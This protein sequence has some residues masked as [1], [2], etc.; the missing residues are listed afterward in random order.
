MQF[1]AYAILWEKFDSLEHYCNATQISINGYVILPIAEKRKLGIIFSYLLLDFNALL[2]KMSAE[3]SVM[4]KRKSG[5]NLIPD[6][7]VWIRICSHFL[8]NMLKLLR[9]FFKCVRDEYYL[10]NWLQ[11]FTMLMT[12]LLKHCSYQ[13]D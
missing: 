8:Q 13:I 2:T 1:S 6:F 10:S 11:D 9:M 7:S 3:W 4:K 12:I 5:G